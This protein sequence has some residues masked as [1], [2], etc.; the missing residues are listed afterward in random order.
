MALSPWVFFLVGLLRIMCTFPFLMYH[1]HYLCPGR[2]WTCVLE[3]GYVSLCTWKCGF[4]NI[5]MFYFEQYNSDPWAWNISWYGYN[6]R[7][8][9]LLFLK[10]F[11]M[12]PAQCDATLFLLYRLN[13]FFIF[14]FFLWDLIISMLEV[15]VL[16]F[17]FGWLGWS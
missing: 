14:K 7:N 10:T 17:D 1:S 15:T 6:T 11:T 3:Y 13:T 9:S 16:N 8:I 4:F 5:V 12:Q 2:P